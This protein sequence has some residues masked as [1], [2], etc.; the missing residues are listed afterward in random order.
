[1]DD[2]GLRVSHSTERLKDKADSAESTA[3]IR[4]IV[5]SEIRTLEPTCSPEYISNSFPSLVIIQAIEHFV[6][7]SR[8][9]CSQD[10][11]QHP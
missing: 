10:W 3:S 7:E 5:S 2:R 4:A 1:M 11:R 9:P 6:V 8:N